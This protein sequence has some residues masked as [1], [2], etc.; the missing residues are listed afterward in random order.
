MPTPPG[1]YDPLDPET[2]EAVYGI[3]NLR[4][5]EEKNSDSV[6]DKANFI[7]DHMHEIRDNDFCTAYLS[8][9][10][11]GR[12]GDRPEATLQPLSPDS[13]DKLVQYIG[14]RIKEDGIEISNFDA[15]C[16]W[17]VNHLHELRDPDLINTYLAST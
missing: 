4:V 8:W 1:P 5:L 13:V 11:A 6:I 17:M 3:V 9:V 2:I 12:V 10:A 15:S 14:F 16:D 7:R